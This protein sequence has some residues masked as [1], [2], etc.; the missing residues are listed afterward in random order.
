[1]NAPVS[2]NLTPSAN[3][4]RP[5][6][7]NVNIPSAYTSNPINDSTSTFLVVF[8]NKDGFENHKICTLEEIFSDSDIINACHKAWGGSIAPRVL[9]SFLYGSQIGHWMSILDLYVIV[10]T[11]SKNPL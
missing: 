4:W 7:N 6:L 11:N 5:I 3:Y 2:S 10:R 1:M 8:K 9:G